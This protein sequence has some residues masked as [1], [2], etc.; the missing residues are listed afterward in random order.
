MVGQASSIAK[1]LG[2]GDAVPSGDEDIEDYIGRKTL[3]GLFY[4]IA[5]KEKSAS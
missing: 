4:M 2:M 3:D 5:E 1:G